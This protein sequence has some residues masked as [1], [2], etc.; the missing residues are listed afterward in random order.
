M[1]LPTCRQVSKTLAESADDLPWH[2]ALL[3]RVHLA[4]CD[5]CAEFARELR[6]LG[7]VFRSFRPQPPAVEALQ[8][9]LL[10]RLSNA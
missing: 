3:L 4:M 5:H 9:K 6:G 8:E 10:K 1:I 2:Q 7:A